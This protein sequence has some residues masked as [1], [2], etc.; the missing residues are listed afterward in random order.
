MNI[1]Q[2]RLLLIS[3]GFRSVD[4]SGLYYVLSIGK[5]QFTTNLKMNKIFAR[6]PDKEYNKVNPY[7]EKDMV[8]DFE[9]D[10]NTL[11]EDIEKFI[12]RF[13]EGV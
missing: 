12:T 1:K 10:E 13:S 11:G 7:S 9:F 6:F 3:L 8:I 4:D 2:I 5:T